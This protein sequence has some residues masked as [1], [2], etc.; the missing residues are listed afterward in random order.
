M[1]FIL[2][3]TYGGYTSAQTIRVKFDTHPLARDFSRTDA[4][5]KLQGYEALIAGNVHYKDIRFMLAYFP[6]THQ[7]ILGDYQAQYLAVHPSICVGKYVRNG[8]IKA[9]THYFTI[10][11]ISDTC[12]YLTP[13][14]SP[15]NKKHIIAS[16]F[17]HTL[18]PVTFV[19]TAPDTVLLKNELIPGKYLYIYFWGT[20]CAGCMQSTHYLK[21]TDSLFCQHLKIIG[22]NYKDTEEEAM[23][24]IQINKIGWLNG[25]STEEINH[26]FLLNSFPYGVLVD[27]STGQIVMLP[28]APK[29]LKDYLTHN[30]GIAPINGGT[31][32][33]L[34]IPE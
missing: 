25:F 24:Y 34:T 16:V 12:A 7:V 4:D 13:S 20:W 27:G 18:P 33:H 5:I 6:P 15:G 8:L 3:C 22:L 19:S 32:A 29:M 17:Q 2:A 21:E 14:S 30:L 23:K 26:E 10:D 9:G 1:F 31:K 11:G 28:L